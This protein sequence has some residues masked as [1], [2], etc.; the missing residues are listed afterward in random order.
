MELRQ[1]MFV[2]MS[3]GKKMNACKSQTHASQ[4]LNVENRK[5]PPASQTQGR[6][7]KLKAHR[8]VSLPERF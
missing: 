6:Q 7:L 8:V 1:L 5:T 3:H 2:K 4:L